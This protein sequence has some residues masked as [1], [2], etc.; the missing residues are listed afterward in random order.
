MYQL[1]DEDIE[2]VVLER[3]APGGFTSVWFKSANTPWD[4]DRACALDAFDYF[5]LEVR[6]STGS[7]SGDEEAGWIAISSQGESEITWD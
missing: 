2:C 3:A 5:G 1:G 4:S 6:C 7:W